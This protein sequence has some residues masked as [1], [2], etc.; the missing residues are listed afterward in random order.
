MHLLVKGDGD[1]LHFVLFYGIAVPDK[2]KIEQVAVDGGWQ[3]EWFY[4]AP[5]SLQTALCVGYRHG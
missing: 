1:R 5:E 4:I 2:F 3:E